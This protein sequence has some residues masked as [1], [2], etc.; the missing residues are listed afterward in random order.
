MKCLEHSSL[1]R[2]FF[3][4]EEF[5]DL[6]EQT[7]QQ[8]PHALAMK[9]RLELRIMMRRSVRWILRNRSLDISDPKTIKLYIKYKNKLL[10]GLTSLI[11]GDD[12]VIF[13]QVRSEL[14]EHN[15]SDEIA[16]RLASILIFFPCFNIIDTT[17][18]VKGNIQNIAD[19]YFVVLDKMRLGSLRQHLNYNN[20]SS[21]WSV[22]SRF[23]L[24]G[25]VDQMQRKLTALI[26]DEYFKGKRNVQPEEVLERA[27]LDYQ[28]VFHKWQSLVVILQSDVKL[29]FEVLYV[30][31]A[32]LDKFVDSLGA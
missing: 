8:I 22:I 13:E 17:I 19:L 23:K 11:R 15:V 10:P 24:K 7:S 25:K 9:L 6:I 30:L 32:E 26:Y 3:V 5:S 14:M 2:H 16:D 28:E 31:V 1:P 12:K 21:R 29:E 27:V 4:L 20:F 18:R